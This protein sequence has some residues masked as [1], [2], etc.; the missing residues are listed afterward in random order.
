MKIKDVEKITGLTQKAIRLYESKGLIC[1]SRDENRYRNY[2]EDDIRKLQTI[3]LLRKAGISIADIK[4]YI[5]GV[6]SLEEIISKRKAEILKESGKRS[7]DY[8]NCENIYQKIDTDDLMSVE[9]LTENEEIVFGEHGELSVGIDIGTTTVSA[10]VY[11]I[12]NRVQ[13]E[14]YSIPHNSYVRSDIFS[15]Q[16]VSDRKSVV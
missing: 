11:D 14:A 2:S 6:M 7:D 10:V 12:D 9:I 13:L 4:L 16:S 5:F 15:E 8:R 3:K 1:I